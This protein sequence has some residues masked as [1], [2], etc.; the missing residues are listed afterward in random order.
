M[1]REKEEK[2][3]FFF[4]L[5]MVL[6]INN[7]VQHRLVEFEGWVMHHITATR[8]ITIWQHLF[9]FSPIPSL[10]RAHAH[11]IHTFYKCLSSPHTPCDHVG[12]PWAL[13]QGLYL[14]EMSLLMENVIETSSQNIA[15]AR[16]VWWKLSRC[17]PESLSEGLYIYMHTVRVRCSLDVQIY[18][19]DALTHTNSP[20]DMQWNVVFLLYNSNVAIFLT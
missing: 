19:Q 6:C 16:R 14:D 17:W 4:Y 1:N 2:M 18:P 15:R 9:L 13:A 5:I 7:L 10:S 3:L 20:P 11:F 12:V 8:S